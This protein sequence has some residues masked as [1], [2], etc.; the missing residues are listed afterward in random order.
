MQLTRKVE[1]ITE[2]EY[3]KITNALSYSS[4]KLFSSDREAFYK[5]CVLLEPAK[6]KTSAS[7]VMGQLVHTLMADLG[8][9]HQKFHIAACIPPTGQ[10]LLLVEEMYRRSLKSMD[11]EGIQKDSF[12]L[13]FQDSVNV[14]K[15]EYDGVT[16]KNFKKKTNEWILQKFQDDGEAYY[17]EC[18]NATGKIVVT[19]GTIEQAEKIVEKLK[20]HEYT[21]EYCDILQDES[22]EVFNELPIQWEENGV[23]YKCMPDRMIIRHNKKIIE[24]VDW[25]TS[26]DVGLPQISY[27]KYGYYLQGAQYR[28][29]VKAWAKSHGLEGYQIPPMKFV[30]CDVNNFEEPVVLLLSE[31]DLDRACRGFTYRGIHYAGLDILLEEI[32]WCLESGRWGTTSELAKNGGRMKLQIR[33]GSQ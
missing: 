5:Q 22:T 9:F 27:L 1:R 16:E 10:I 6:E 20:T 14:V 2:K 3:R 26:W 33:Y 29:G 24:S 23:P 19:M 28:K 13:I 8:D 4:I 30:F 32:A 21:R 12:S 17:R 31:D 18:L 11:E 15:Y 7:L 25:K